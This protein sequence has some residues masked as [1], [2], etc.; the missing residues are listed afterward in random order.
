MITK[1]GKPAAVLISHED[2]ESL[3]E[4]LEILGDPDALAAIKASLADRSRFTLDEVRADLA[5][6]AA[7]EPEIDPGAGSGGAA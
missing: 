5:N 7:T 2:L 1:N 4:T 6:R 3:E